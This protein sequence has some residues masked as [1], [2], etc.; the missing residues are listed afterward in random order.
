MQEVIIKDEFIKLDQLLKYVGVAQT[1][2]ESKYLISNE[3]VKVNGE[4]VIQRGKKI[5]SGD[6]VEVEGQVETY[7][8]K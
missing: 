7:L 6:Q 8:V 4:V 5:R 1:G 2:G 3:M